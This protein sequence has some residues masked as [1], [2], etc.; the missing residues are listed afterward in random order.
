[1]AGIQYAGEYILKEATLVTASGVVLDLKG[2]IISF[3][4]V[5]LTNKI[6]ESLADFI[7]SKARDLQCEGNYY[8]NKSKCGIGFHGDAERLKVIGVR[9]GAMVLIYSWFYNSKPIGKPIKLELKDG[10]LY[11]MSEKATGNDWKY[12]SKVTL[13]HAAGCEKYTKL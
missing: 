12:R 6:R 7:G 10:D 2:T 5:K 11:I 3:D 13:R 1:M 8:F 9:I 4:K